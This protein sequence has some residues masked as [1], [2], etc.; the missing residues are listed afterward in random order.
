MEMTW[1]SQRFVLSKR[2]HLHTFLVVIV[3]MPGLAALGVFLG[4]WWGM[5]TP[6]MLYTAASFLTMYHI[7]GFGITIGY[8]RLFTHGSFRARPPVRVALAIMGSTAWEQSLIKW[9]P[10]HKIHHALADKPGDPHSPIVGGDGSLW[11][12][13][14]MFF[15]AHEGWIIS[16]Y[17]YPAE[18]IESFRN[19]LRQ[20]K[21]VYFQSK[22]QHVWAVGG[23]ILPA[24]IALPFW[25]WQGGLQVLL[26]AGALRVVCVWHATWFINSGTHLWGT[27][28]N[29]LKNWATNFALWLFGLGEAFHNNHHADERSAWHGWRW[30]D[31]DP[32]KWVI[33]TLEK[34]RL[35]Y[36]VRRPRISKTL[37]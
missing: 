16:P 30:Y 11:S 23:L 28:P 25:G 2:F 19:G 13:I 9:V 31:P 37:A 22:T 14:L 34:L 24:I 4:L 1:G 12:Q 3:V 10:I 15:W 17:K 27:K 29:K 32:S 8:H 18:I 6:L 36:D 20:Q 21:V 33:W 7:S 35:V 26:I 5:S